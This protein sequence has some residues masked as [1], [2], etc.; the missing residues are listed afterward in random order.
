MSV[1][2][3]NER[4]SR[5]N[6]IEERTKV[7]VVVVSDPARSDNRFE[8]NRL[9]KEKDDASYEI[10]SK[11]ENNENVNL[12]YTKKEQKFEKPA[13]NLP[14]PKKPKKKEDNIFKKI[15]KALIQPEK[16]KTRN[17]R[18]PSKQ[19]KKNNKYK[20]KNNPQNKKNQNN[21]K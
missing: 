1:F 4:R 3:L 9:K 16:E 2:L 20:G 10:Q 21:K 14:P 8:V 12:N 19:T 11:L 6:E 13:V 7:R 15:F 5:I 17:K 18:K